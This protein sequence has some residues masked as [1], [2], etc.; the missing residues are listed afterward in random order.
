M[1]D[2]Y[3]KHNKF[4]SAANKMPPDYATM[5]ELL[6][7]GVDINTY[8]ED[9]DSTFLSDAFE[10]YILDR[11]DYNVGD[12]WK[13]Q[14]VQRGIDG[15]Y[16]PDLTRFFLNHGYDVNMN[17]HGHGGKALLGL[18]H[19][20]YDNYA[21]EAAK[22]LL[23]AGADVNY[24]EYKDDY[25]YEDVAESAWHW[26]TFYDGHDGHPD[27]VIYSAIVD[28]AELFESYQQGRMIRISKDADDDGEDY[29]IYLSQTIEEHAHDGVHV[30]EK[31]I[32]AELHIDEY[33]LN[34]LLS[35]YLEKYYNPKYKKNVMING[36][37]SQYYH[38]GNYHYQ[39]SALMNM[40]EEMGHIKEL[41]R[42]DYQSVSE[43]ITGRFKPEF[44][45][46]DKKTLSSYRDHDEFM[47]DN[48]RQIIM[49]YEDFI[50]EME[51]FLDIASKT[52]KYGDCSVAFISP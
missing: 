14:A 46:K 3:E 25:P 49:F 31:C 7:E 34:S 48:I 9:D 29:A 22:I 26:C 12:D 1:S 16:L 6:S 33:V 43:K 11:L 39:L 2:I 20:S 44:I 30:E 35:Y 8:D 17:H 50:N 36:E 19:S 5:E 13:A 41:L 42:M 28:L 47:Q 37:I 15:R 52:G 21:L 27:D 40:V 24:V 18:I 51:L 32:S 45:V 23:E 38:Y 4:I 10:Y